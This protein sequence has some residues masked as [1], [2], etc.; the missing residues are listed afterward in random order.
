MPGSPPSAAFPRPQSI[1][2]RPPLCARHVPAQRQEPRPQPSFMPP[3]LR[4][5]SPHPREPPQGA[6][7]ARFLTPSPFDAFPPLLPD[8]LLQNLLLQNDLRVPVSHDG[9]AAPSREQISREKC[10]GKGGSR[11]P[12]LR[13]PPG[14]A[15]RAPAASR[16][17]PGTSCPQ[18]LLWPAGTVR[19]VGACVPQAGTLGLRSRSCRAW[20]LR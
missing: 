8:P 12:E 3:E 19:G 18:A 6:R 17:G 15:S 4:V 10:R 11:R 9:R 5:T 13:G 16:L 2:A 7:G 1:S 14:G 20:G